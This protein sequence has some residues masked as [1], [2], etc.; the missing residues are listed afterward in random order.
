MNGGFPVPPGLWNKIEQVTY[1][2]GDLQSFTA[3]TAQPVLARAA[4][5]VLRSID[6]LQAANPFSILTEFDKWFRW[7]ANLI[8]MRAKVEAWLK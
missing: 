5:V 7:T 3:F 1:T 8:K 6:D 2:E 4:P